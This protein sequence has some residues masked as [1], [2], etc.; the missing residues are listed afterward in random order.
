MVNSEQT[1]QNGIDWIE[2]YK[3]L[4]REN[5]FE[6]AEEILLSV[7]DYFERKEDSQ[8]YGVPPYAYDELALI[9]RKQNKV[10]DEIEILERFSKQKH[11]PGVK[12]PKLLARLE[13]LKYGISS[14]TI[15]TKIKNEKQI[16]EKPIF[17]KESEFKN[18]FVVFDV[19]IANYDVSS[20][21]QIGAVRFSNNEII[22]EFNTYVN[23]E[24]L[25]NDFHIG[26]HGIT[27]EKT[28]TSPP[29]P[30]AFEDFLDFL[31]GDILLSYTT[32]DISSLRKACNKYSLRLPSFKY[33]D[34]S[35][36]VRHT[37]DQ[38]ARDGFGLA[39]VANDLGILF[40]HHDA[41]ADSRV[42]GQV[43]VEA[44]K[45]SK[46]EIRDW[47]KKAT[48]TIDLSKDHVPPPSIC[49]PGNTEGFLF[50]ETILFTGKLSIP[51]NQAATLAAN[52]GCNIIDRFNL[53][54]TI[55]VIGELDP[56]ALKGSS[57]SSKQ[58]Q[59]E[60]AILNGQSIRIL[61]EEDFFEMIKF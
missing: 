37:W 59:A 43:V 52:A 55:L 18:S 27:P 4:K 24:D 5:N 21:C 17:E 39:C 10:K 3:R 49:Q 47:V 58:K 42:A 60:K 36:I 35:R 8:E 45:E 50:G 61:S 1:W 54:T 32:F 19:E 30:K 2:G 20:I 28:K 7:I 31:S 25:F 34:A 12:P 51:R 13:L 57:K 33:I 11:G 22:G 23:P 26:I 15:K 40:K 29:F 44:I 38:Y 6:K 53:T 14:P 48:R 9:Y 46:I 56:R 41:L 16:E